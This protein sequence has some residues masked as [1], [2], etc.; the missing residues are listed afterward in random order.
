[1]TTPSDFLSEPEIG[2][3][4]HF[5]VSF[6]DYRAIKATNWSLLKL[7]G[8]SM[9]RFRYEVQHP[10]PPNDD[11]IRE[12]MFHAFSQDPAC[13]TYAEYPETYPA[14]VKKEEVQK[15]WNMNANFCRAF[16]ADLAAQGVKI[17]PHDKMW[18]ARRMSERIRSLPSAMMLIEGGEFE[19][20]LVWQDE[21][22]GL[23]C[24]GR[25]DVLKNGGIG[26]LKGTRQNIN[27]DSWAKVCRGMGYFG[28]V[29][30]YV[31][32]AL[33]AGIPKLDVPLF[34][35]MVCMNTPPY[36]A[37]CWDIYDVEDSESRAFLEFG[38]AKVSGYLAAV[39]QALDDE[40]WPGPTW[41]APNQD[42]VDELTVPEWMR[43]E[44]RW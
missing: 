3:G 41:Q 12:T 13:T 16:V 15:P 11:Y 5:G 17:V 34:R 1:M 43:L 38:R 7:I 31:D 37:A 32:G 19:V 27:N 23:W 2:A 6:E 40:W 20:T 4:V 30:M 44:E 10:K 24:K 22:T 21:A 28:Q 33:A 25:L 26:E 39:K 8:E 42:P 9:E 36:S 18:D 14:I 35:F 29:A